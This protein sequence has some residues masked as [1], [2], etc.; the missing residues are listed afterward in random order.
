MILLLAALAGCEQ[1][2]KGWREVPPVP[3]PPPVRSVAAPKPIQPHDPGP[4]QGPQAV[5]PFEVQPR[6]GPE[7]VQP[8][9]QQP[10]SAKA[11]DAQDAASR[12]RS[13]S[14]Q[15]A[16]AQKLLDDAK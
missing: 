10:V 7:P 5:R 9:E 2:A 15:E 11:Y 13:L 3:K 14:L 16:A 1:Q 8:H 12:R 6:R 4:F